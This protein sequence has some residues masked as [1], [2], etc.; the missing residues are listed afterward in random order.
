M[1]SSKD[2]IRKGHSTEW[3]KIFAKHISTTG[4]ILSI[5]FS[6]Y[7]LSFGG[8]GGGK[9]LEQ[10]TDKEKSQIATKHTKRCSTMLVIGETQINIT[11]RNHNT[12]TRIFKVRN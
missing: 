11:V 2:I 4:L 9:S 6:F 3:K 7:Y 10:T 1:C 8:D 5:H 12:L